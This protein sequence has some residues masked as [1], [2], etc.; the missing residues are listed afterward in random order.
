MMA[1]P[2][3]RTLV[4]RSR[5]LTVRRAKRLRGCFLLQSRTIPIQERGPD[6]SFSVPAVPNLNMG[7][8]GECELLWSV[9]P[10]PP[11]ALNF[12]SCRIC[13]Q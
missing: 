13:S 5:C 6:F 1:T 4:C 7:L 10:S 8:A 2:R 12:G 9:G 3:Q 11:R